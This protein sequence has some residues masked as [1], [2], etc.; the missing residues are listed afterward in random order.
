MSLFA[1]TRVT[2]ISVD[3]GVGA[4]SNYEYKVFNEEGPSTSRKTI[5][6]K[7]REHKVTKYVQSWPNA[8]ER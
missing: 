4:Q 6:K 1:D 8:N 3:Q 2:Y 5:A 7:D